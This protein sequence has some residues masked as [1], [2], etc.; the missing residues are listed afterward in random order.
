MILRKNETF[1]KLV[2]IDDDVQPFLSKPVGS[3]YG[4]ILF[5]FFDENMR[6]MTVHQLVNL[7]LNFQMSTC[8]SQHPIRSC[9]I[10]LLQ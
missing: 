7:I 10:S 4:R 1:A 2:A 3:Y 6:L 5:G 9:R 8:T